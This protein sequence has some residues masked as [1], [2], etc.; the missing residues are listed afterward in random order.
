MT[1]KYK[2]G[3]CGKLYVTVNSDEHGICEIF[4]N[5]GEEGC[6]ALT[7]AVGRLLSISIRA[8]MDLESIKSQVEGIRCITCIAD[9]DTSV[10][11]CPDAIG[12]AIE[13]A[14]NGYNKFDLDVTGGPRSVMICPEADCG[15]IMEPEGG[16]YVCRN[17]GYS[18]CS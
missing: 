12:K 13:F 10:L 17:C 14:V 9:S 6:A 1:K 11:S 8:G 15:G 3:G 5:T 2:I 4:T 16:C 7:E 18:K